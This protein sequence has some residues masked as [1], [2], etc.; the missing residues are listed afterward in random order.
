MRPP[1]AQLAEGAAGLALAGLGSG[2]GEVL[3]EVGLHLARGQRLLAAVQLN[4][5]LEQH[6]SGQRGFVGLE[7]HGVHAAH[8]SGERELGRAKGLT[9]IETV[10]LADEH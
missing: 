3:H 6:P 8:A 9:I 5:G 4:A 2:L 10:S 7:L 1:S